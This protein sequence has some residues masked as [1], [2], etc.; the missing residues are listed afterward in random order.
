MVRWCWVN[1]QCRGIPLILIIVGQ[2]P[3]ALT[4]GAGWGCLVVNRVYS[5]YIELDIFTTLNIIFVYS[6]KIK[7]S[8]PAHVYL[9]DNLVLDFRSGFTVND[10]GLTALSSFCNG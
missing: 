5:K 3:T 10:S 2:G 1:F 6:Q 4:V 9:F 7:D 8:C